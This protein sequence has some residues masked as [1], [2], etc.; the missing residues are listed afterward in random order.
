MSAS[1]SASALPCTSRLD[2]HGDDARLV[3]AQLREHILGARRLTRQLHVAELALAVERHFARLALAL[4]ARGAHR[5][6]SARPTGPAP[7]PAWTAGPPAPAGR[8]RRTC[9]RTRPNSEPAM[10]GSPMRSVPLLDQHGR[11]RAAALLDAR[12]DHDAG[13]QPGARRAQL[14]HFRLQQDRPR[15]ADRFPA[16]CGPRPLHEHVLAAPLLGDHLLLGELGAHPVRVRIALVD[17]VDGD[18]DRHTRGARVLDRLDGLRHD[19]V[20]GRHH[21]DHDV[22]RLRAA[23]AHRGEG[24]VAR[25]VEEGDDALRRLDVIGADVLGDAAGFAGRHLGAADVVEQR[26][27]AVIDVAHDGD[28]RRPRLERPPSPAARP[29]GPSSIW[30]SLQELR[31]CGPSPRPPAPPCPDR[32]A[33]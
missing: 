24:G 6:H 22:G 3:L 10:I 21:Q 29:A 19:A 15:A 28:D 12:L 31:R 2:E 20:V 18:D 17:L 25:G 32:S 11:H 7:R 4:D 9:A 30:F 8:S 14:Q 13:G 16:R 26:G 5:R 33:G 23:R 1:R 27:L